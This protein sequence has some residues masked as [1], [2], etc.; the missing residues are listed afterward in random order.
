MS[1]PIEIRQDDN[2]QAVGPYISRG[3]FLIAC[4]TFAAKKQIRDVVVSPKGELG[5]E[6]LDSQDLAMPLTE[7]TTPE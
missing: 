4:C 3:T 2:R 5:K 7:L 1:S 6:R